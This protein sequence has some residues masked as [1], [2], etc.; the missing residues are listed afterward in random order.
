MWLSGNAG[1]FEV[2]E[3]EGKLGLKS[4]LRILHISDLHF[5]PGQNAK[6]SFLKDLAF[7]KPDLVVNTGD[8]LG[9]KDAINPTLDALAPLLDFPGV[10]VNGSNDYRSPSPRNP[11]KYFAGPSDVPAKPNLDTNR[12][13][14]ELTNAGWLDLN[15]S[16][17]SLDIQNQK[18]GFLGLDDPHENLDDLPS[19]PKQAAE[20]SG[21]DLV[22]GVSHAPY[23]RVIEAFGNFGAQLMF[24]GHTHG[25]QICMPGTRALVTN[26]D[27]PTKYAQ[28]L[29]AWK[30]QTNDTMLHVSGGM[31]C[32]I[33]A[34]VRLF[35]PPSA[36]LLTV[37]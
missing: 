28:G 19:L 36:T 13:T 33:Y 4:P 5:A 3:L 7:L 31:G 26:C 20:I 27:L 25:G 35:C 34:P 32:S 29:S 22:I 2:I 8:N 11:F 1:P 23:L 21:S 37:S 10:F 16:S 30:G 12:F 24:A 17:G 14:T 18:L 15:N 9:H 6:R